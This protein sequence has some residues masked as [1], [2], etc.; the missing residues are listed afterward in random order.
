MSY[1]HGIYTREAATSLTAPLE[2]DSGL[3]V[4]VGTAP[5]NLAVNPAAAV[6]VPILAYSK[7]EA[8]A[9]IGYSPDFSYTLNQAISAAFEVHGVAPIVLINVLD[10]DNANHKT[11]VAAAD[12]AVTAGKLTIADANGNV[13]GV[14][15]DTVVV[16]LTSSSESALVL[17]TD[18]TIDFDADGNCSIVLLNNTSATTL[19][20]AYSKLNPDGV[21]ASDVIGAVT[22]ATGAATGLE[23]VRE[24]YPRFG[25]VPGIIL[26]PGFSRLP[27]V[28]AAIEAKTE[29]INGRFSAFSI[30]DIS[31]DENDD[32]GTYAK[33]YTT[34]A[35]AKES[36]GVDSKNTAAYW[37]MAKIG[38]KLYWRSALMGAAYAK[39]DASN[40]GVPYRSPSN[41]SSGETGACLADGSAVYLDID[42]A[43]LLNAQGICT[44][45]NENGY[46]AWGNRTAAYPSTTD[47]KDMWIA[48]RRMFIWWKNTICLSYFQHVDAPMSQRLIENIVNTEQI[49]GNALVSRGYLAAAR[50]EYRAEENSATDIIDGKLTFHLFLAPY[51]P[52]EEIEFVAEFDVAALASALSQEVTD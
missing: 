12:M 41:I 7:T 17:D 10:P 5:V 36:L 29:S 34:V 45:V 50:I 6:N 38:D 3:Q 40:G 24:V 44:S 46:K 39:L 4:I 37:P 1:R 13:G 22:A 16:K 28:A 14:L 43:N 2:A 48:V 32:Q 20:V 18:Y 49:R 35:D 25:L 19:N 11:S 8:A 51:T 15:A 52:A 33:V 9:A 31:S 23:L 21:T 42:Q 27:A 47:P 30:V 26:A